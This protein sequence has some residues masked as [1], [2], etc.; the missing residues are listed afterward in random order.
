MWWHL[1]SPVSRLFAQPLFR[2]RSEKIS[3]LHVTGLCE[4]NPLVT[5]GFPSQRASNAE[6][7][8]FDDVIMRKTKTWLSYKVNTMAAVDLVTQG[9]K[10]SAAMFFTWFSWNIMASALIKAKQIHFC[11]AF[12]KPEYYGIKRIHYTLMWKI[13]TCDKWGIKRLQ[14][15]LCRVWNRFIPH[16]SQ[17][18]IY[19]NQGVV[20]SLSRSTVNT[21][22]GVF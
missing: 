20:N 2:R 15:R 21:N 14:T 5:H 9:T 1:K 12:L 16:E 22:K 13:D 10:A 19:H 18:S 17:V 6:L 4:G 11:H 7:L 8:S 3:K